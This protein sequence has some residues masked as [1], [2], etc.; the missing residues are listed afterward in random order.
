MS[1][2][3]DFWPDFG[4]G[5]DPPPTDCG[6]GSLASKVLMEFGIAHVGTAGGSL[7]NL[8]IKHMNAENVIKW[9]LLEE[10]AAGGSFKEMMVNEHGVVEFKEIGMSDGVGGDVYY[11]IQSATYIEK[12]VGVMVTGGKPLVKRK[13]V[14]F[15]EIWA[16]GTK[17]IYN[18]FWLSE[19]GMSEKFSQHATIVFDDPQLDTKYKDGIDNLYDMTSPWE[20]ILGYARYINWEGSENSPE[21]TVERA[22]T[23]T[24]PILIS[25]PENSVVYDAPLGKLQ[26]RKPQPEPGGVNLSAQG[27]TAVASDGIKVP[28]PE[29]FRYTT[30]RGT[31]V[32]KL[33]EI[34]SVVIV[35][36]KVD[37]LIGIP[38]DDA[39]AVLGSEADSGSAKIL[40]SINSTKDSMYT[41]K[42]GEHY[43]I[44]Y[45]DDTPYVVFAS[46]ARALD[47][48][49]F[50]SGITVLIDEDSAFS[51]G[52]KLTDVS[53]LPTGGTD[54][55]LVKQV[56]VLI[57]IQT[58]CINIFDPRPGEALKIANSLSYQLCPLISIEEPAPIAFNGGLIDQAA[59]EVDHDPTTT[60]SLIDTDY[61]QA[62]DKMDGGGM[63]VTLSFL[64][65]SQCALMSDNLFQY[66]NSGSGSVTTYICGPNAK[67]TLGGSGADSASVVN[68]I[69]YSYSDSNSYTISVTTG[70]KL[71]GGFC[72]L[73]QGIT[74]KTTENVP[75]TGRIIQ[76][77]GNHVFFKVLLDGCGLGPVV[78]VNTAA[79]VLR[80]GDRVSCT[81]YNNPVEQ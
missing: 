30:V 1:G 41:L 25:G 54:G 69:T 46:N 31:K 78:A 80:V 33:I 76:D 62:I 18:A 60:Q 4:K 21:T 48:A 43:A 7:P 39:A 57:N 52:E 20:S 77:M 47:P 38:V 35:G 8:D 23:S 63:T 2:P 71:L 59:G 3:D 6:T 61:E 79:K 53:V 49:E 75:S 65:K 24:I 16:G 26:K 55:Y 37:T 72:D 64:D 58:P 32:D 74:M 11:Q 40:L 27:T 50:G 19:N 73:V 42:A 17:E 56:I 70:P 67:P 22:N 66:L 29:S 14:N 68:D 81:V 51:A 36:R 10:G 34:R 45:E 5:D 12:C 28:I 13:A 44:A 9:S 15:K